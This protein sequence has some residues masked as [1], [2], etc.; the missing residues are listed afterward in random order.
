MGRFEILE[1][2]T[3]CPNNVQLLNPTFVGEKE[4]VRCFE[5]IQ[6]QSHDYMSANQNPRKMFLFF[7]RR[8][9]GKF[10]VARMYSTVPVHDGMIKF[11]RYTAI[12][13]ILNQ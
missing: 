9:G 3:S 5:K 4:G 11:L 8:E 2:Q 10:A 7:E 12:M 1:A 13:S 6:P